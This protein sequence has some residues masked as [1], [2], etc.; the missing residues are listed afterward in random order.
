[1][2][3]RNGGKG[4]DAYDFK[5]G[6]GHDTVVNTGGEGAAQDT[7]SFGSGILGFDWLWFERSG[8]DLKVS[9]LTT[10]AGDDSDSITVKDWNDRRNQLTFEL[11]NGD[12]L[13]W[14]GADALAKKMEAM[15]RP[16]AGPWT[17]TDDLTKTVND[18]SF[19]ES[20]AAPGVSGGPGNDWIYGT[21][22]LSHTIDGFGGDDVLSGGLAGDTLNGGAGADRLFG[23][24][25][26]D[27]L[28][29]GGEN[30]VL[31]GGDGKDTLKGGDGDDK[32]YG[33]AGRDYLDGGPGNDTLYSGGD[34]DVLRGGAGE[35]AFHG[36]VDGAAPTV[37][38]DD[39]PDGVT[40]D[41]TM[42]WK[43]TGAGDWKQKGDAAGDTY[44]HIRRVRGSEHDD[45]I[46][47]NDEVNVI[48]GSGGGDEI[49]G[50]GDNDWLFGGDGAD[51]LDGGAGNDWLTGDDGVD[52][53]EGGAGND[54][55]YGGSGR[56]TYK[57][58]AEDGVDTVVNAG[59]EGAAQD[60][61]K[62]GPSIE[63]ERLW[64]EKS[65]NDLKVSVLSIQDG[66]EGSITVKDWYV[67]GPGQW[68]YD[69]RLTFEF[70]DKDRPWRLS[71]SGAEALAEAMAKP[72][73]TRPN[74]IWTTNREAWTKIVEA[75]SFEESGAA[76]GVSGG[77]KNDW[78]YGTGTVSHTIDGFGGDD[79]LIGGLAGDTLNGGDGADRLF[80]SDGDDKLYGGDG[81]DKLYGGDGDD[82]LY[83]GPGQDYLD[84]G[85]G[86]DTLY[87][88]GDGDVLRGGAGGDAFHGRRDGAAPTVFYDDAPDG[89][90]VDLKAPENNTGHAKDDTYHHIR[91]VR[92]SEHD[93]RIR[94]N[95][96]VNV[97]RGSGGDDKLYG[98]GGNDMLRGGAGND[99]LEGGAGD[100]YWLEGGSGRDTYSFDAGDGADTVVNAGEGAAQDTVSFGPGILSFNWL[101]FE[102]SGDDLKVSVLT[103]AAGDSG[104]SITVKDWYAG[105]HNQLTFKLG[106]KRL[107]WSGAD[108]LAT[109]M[110]AMTRPSAGPWTWTDDLT[111]TVNDYSFEESGAFPGVSGGS[112]ND[113]IYGEGSGSHTIDGFGGDDVL[114]GGL[115]GDTLKGGDGADRLFGND[116]DDKLY[117]GDGR[118]KLY[119]GDGDD[120]LYGDAGQDYLDGGPGNDTLYS[121][122]DRDVLRGGAGR[123]TFHGV[124]DG[125]APTVFYDDAP[126]GVVVDL[127]MEWE[128]TRAGDWEQKGDAA[129]D[130]Y[131]NIRRVRG[132]DHD[133]RIRGNDK[134]NVIR[135]SGGDDKLYG[136]GGNDTL[137]GG[138]GDDTLTGGEGNDT[139]D[140][141]SGDDTLTG[142]KGR[143]TYRFG[144]AGG[145]DVVDNT[146]GDSDVES[147]AGDKVRFGFGLKAKHLWFERPKDGSGNDLN[148]LRV[149]IL[150]TDDS[151]TV[152]DWYDGTTTQRVGFELSDGQLLTQAGAEALV[153]AMA[154]MTQ[155]TGADASEWTSTQYD[156]LKPIMAPHGWTV[157][158]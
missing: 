124:V 151:I 111:K 64:F 79:V 107:S 54:L 65:G 24:G 108:A 130:T 28:N 37:F 6:D 114:I 49:Y 140:G 46:R 132:S 152:K 157:T 69:N 78:I 148:D 25:G 144:R 123:D 53:L 96:E 34:R 109:K 121:G 154:D 147:A 149:E 42:E 143:D 89:V 91:R 156:T 75:H 125:A 31:Y 13:S 73:V 21:G 112:K 158:S 23:N 94:G 48:R 77:S 82:E 120:K 12:R 35:D 155:P 84:G 11:H 122:G 67:S 9:V 66:Y 83:G 115:A 70:T 142:G 72:E 59:G 27:T 81:R 105:Q 5:I 44:H 134:V 57:F 90:V 127:M 88:G 128:L 18:H 22:A 7:V 97:I 153:N 135:G 98:R 119:G 118:D 39:A 68:P 138:S 19:K 106:N 30:D 17:W 102:R 38:Y 87:S 110:E 129:G 40:V 55:L 10:A 63:V 131:I 41:L 50:L 33:G 29:G 104:G 16:S 146:G 71:W 113:W 26:N 15:T 80:G 8:D 92:G 103:T 56:D 85:D 61:V 2:T 74:S 14:S 52:T 95:D 126:S 145:S 93:D 137:Y 117:G 58:D 133:D 86:D 45:R 3:T 99:W 32:L 20:G 60:T 100:D 51:T 43:R 136:R 76:P 139:L 47:G 116:G 150:G 4:R 141:G 36:R 101:W 1:M 62:F